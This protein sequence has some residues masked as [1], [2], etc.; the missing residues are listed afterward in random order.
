MH[1]VYLWVPTKGWKKLRE[2]TDLVS[3]VEYATALEP[4]EV[5]VARA[6]GR[7]FYGGVLCMP[8]TGSTAHRSLDRALPRP[9]AV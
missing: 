3:A 9:A 5:K 2:F 6:D 1:T 7:C 8:V 4:L